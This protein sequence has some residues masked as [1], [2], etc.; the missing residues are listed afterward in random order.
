MIQGVPKFDA[1]AVFNGEFSF[2]GPTL[3]LKVKAAF[4][5]TKTGHTHGWTNGEGP[6][7]SKN[8]M[9]ILGKLR[10][11]MEDDL[12]RLHLTDGSTVPEATGG[13]VEAGGGGLG[14]H[15]GSGGED[16]PPL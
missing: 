5:D 10:E 2:M 1:L 9:D 12:A 7:W 4:V 6:I 16:A 11:A 13:A 8:T 3:T 14:E 15:L